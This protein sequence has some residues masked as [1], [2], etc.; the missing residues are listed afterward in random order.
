MSGDGRLSKSVTI[1]LRETVEPL[2]SSVW[3]TRR[4][5]CAGGLIAAYEIHIA[6][7]RIAAAAARP[8]DHRRTIFRR[9]RRAL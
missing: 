9:R 1:A 7:M 2:I 5:V 6:A 4:T 8:P 3:P